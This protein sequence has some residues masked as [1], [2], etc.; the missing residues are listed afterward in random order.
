MHAVQLKI[1]NWLGRLPMSLR[2]LL[3][4]A[5]WLHAY[6][7][8][9]SC[10]EDGGSTSFRNIHG[11]LSQCSAI[12]P[13]SQCRSLVCKPEGKTELEIDGRKM[14]VVRFKLGSSGHG[15]G[16]VGCPDATAELYLP[17]AGT[18]DSRAAV[19]AVGFS[20]PESNP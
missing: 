15:K 1:K 16:P 18:R 11:F 3:L 10:P 19:Q 9:L 13:S 20:R 17:G 5:C 2:D 7:T 4:E 14:R 8:V 6:I 12:Q